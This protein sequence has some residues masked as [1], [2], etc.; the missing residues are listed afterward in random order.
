MAQSLSLC[1]IFVLYKYSF[2]NL[3]GQLVYRCRDF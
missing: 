1:A 3:Q 2:V